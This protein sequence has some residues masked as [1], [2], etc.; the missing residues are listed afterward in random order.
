VSQPTANQITRLVVGSDGVADAPIIAVSGLNRPHGMAFHDG[1]FYIANTDGVVR[2]KID[3]S[4]HAVGTPEQVNH[5]SSG[6]M[7]WT[8]SIAFGP[9]GRMYVAA[10]SDCNVCVEKDSTRAAVMQY[11]ENG[12]NG[13]VYARGL[14]NAVGIAFNPATGDLWVSQNERDNIEPDHQNLPPEEL[15]IIHD[16]G[17]YGWPYC[18]GDRIPNPEF[19]D[20]ARCANTIPPALEMQAH[21]APLSLTF[22]KDATQLPAAERG[23]A[24]IAF[25]GSW[26]RD[27]P[28]GAKVVRVHIQNNT[29]VSYDDFITGWQGPDGKRWGRPVDVAVLHDGSLVISDNSSGEIIRVATK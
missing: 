20:Q 12:K 15:N 3:S 2:V 14:R 24:L 26:D 7:H 21:S 17:D 22:L 19:N 27:E 28:T 23:D 16:G 11:D 6:G 4:G 13:R 25:H 5:Y 1:W 8:R 10:G 9:D 18:Y 29:P